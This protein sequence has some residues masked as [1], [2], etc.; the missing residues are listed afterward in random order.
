[1]GNIIL[2][3]WIRW[4]RMLQDGCAPVTTQFS[5]KSSIEWATTMEKGVEKN[6]KCFVLHSRIELSSR[7]GYILAW[8]LVE[9]IESDERMNRKCAASW[10]LWILV[11]LICKRCYPANRQATRQEH[12]SKHIETIRKINSIVDLHMCSHNNNF[13][14]VSCLLCCFLWWF[15]AWP[16]VISFFG[17]C[18]KTILTVTG[19]SVVIKFVRA[20]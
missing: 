9:S 13:C 17:T 1:M 8:F 5:C 16:K 19:I 7:A 12:E 15:C 6:I 20:R 10:S 3:E 14:F 18:T 11:Y 2:N 4:Y